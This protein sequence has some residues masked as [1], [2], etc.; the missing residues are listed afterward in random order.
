M[1]T[2]GT[3]KMRRARATEGR[4]RKESARENGGRRILSSC[5][6][7][8]ELELGKARECGRRWGNK[9]RVD[10]ERMNVGNEVR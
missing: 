9:T 4:R 2:G 7:E 1:L 10:V 5:G 8:R 3:Q 6:K